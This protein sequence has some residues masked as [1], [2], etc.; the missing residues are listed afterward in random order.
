MEG[1]DVIA[2]SGTSGGGRAARD[3]VDHPY[4]ITKYP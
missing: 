3:P 2:I 1:A 4:S